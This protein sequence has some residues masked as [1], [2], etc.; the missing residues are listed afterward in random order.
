MFF[1]IEGW[2]CLLPG[3]SLSFVMVAGLIFVFCL[4]RLVCLMCS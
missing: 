1:V 2:C 3:I 4:V